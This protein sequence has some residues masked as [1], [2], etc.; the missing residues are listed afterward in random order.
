MDD[1]KEIKREIRNDIARKLESFSQ[2]EVSAK[3]RQIERRLLEFA[4]FIEAHVVLLYFSRTGEVDTHR[5]I[6]HCYHF[7][8]IVVIPY[9][10]AKA[11]KTQLLKVDNPETDMVS[12]DDLGV[13][14]DPA[15]CRMVPVDSIEIAVVPGLVFDEKGARIGLGAGIYDK[16]IPRLPVTTRKVSLAFEDQIIQ[17]VPK[18]SI[19]RYVDI[20]ITEKRTIYKI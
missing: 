6:R 20:I 16:L 12:S 1:V 3:S 7:N 4:N 14:P 17:Q 13:I 9:F 2:D 5:I 15:R 10:D 11:K 8:K 19:D 18:G